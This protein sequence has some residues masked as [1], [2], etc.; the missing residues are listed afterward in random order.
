MNDT[1]AA[2]PIYAVVDTAQDPRLYGLVQSC[3]QPMCL[4]F[5]NVAEPLNRAAPY[6]VRIDRQEPLYKAWVE[7][8]SG[9][10]WGIF[11]RSGLPIEQL[12]RRLR[13]FLQVRL[14]DGMIV[15]FRFYDPRVF[16]AFIVTCSADELSAWFSGVAAYIVQRQGEPGYFDYGFHGGGLHDA[17]R[18]LQR[19]P[20]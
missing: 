13:H 7:E 8:G 10:N 6:L 14:P 20:G 15:Q 19:L 2:E 18:P 9:R 1:Q 11:I 12:A 3:S 4:F 5:G 16:N 17:G